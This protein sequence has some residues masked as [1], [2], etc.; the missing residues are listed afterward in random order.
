MPDVRTVCR[1][2]AV[3][4]ATAGALG[5]AGAFA[6]SPG[7][8]TATAE[9]TIVTATG[10]SDATA[11]CPSGS[12]VTG[13]GYRLDQYTVGPDDYALAAESRPT[14]DGTGW[15]AFLA[16]SGDNPRITVYAVCTSP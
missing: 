5:T 2:I 8:A 3:V 15:Y 1:R 9:P 13:G 4:L 12:Y 6:L 11:T 7:A 10:G 16:T 14:D